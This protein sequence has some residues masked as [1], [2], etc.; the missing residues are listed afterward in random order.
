MLCNTQTIPKLVSLK[1]DGVSFINNIEYGN[2]G[3]RVWR[4]YAVGLGK[5]LPWSKFNFQENYSVP[6][7]NILKEAKVPKAEFTLVIARRNSAQTQ[8]A[9]DQVTVGVAEDTGEQDD[10]DVEY[11]SELSRVLKMDA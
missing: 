3:T 8:L 7:L 5:F 11:R 9:E 10:D 1:W 6:V 2:E 4:S